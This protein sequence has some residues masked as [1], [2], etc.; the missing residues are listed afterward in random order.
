MCIIYFIIWF[1]C[2]FLGSVIFFI[3]YD[4]DIISEIT[5]EELIPFFVL[6]VL[7][8]VGLVLS[9]IFVVNRNIPAVI[10]SK[11]ALS[12]SRRFVRQTIP[13]KIKSEVRHAIRKLRRNTNSGTPK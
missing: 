10:V 6:T 7:G 12:K 11:D 1:L 13:D 9:I 5:R 8:P 2:G 3:F 4:D